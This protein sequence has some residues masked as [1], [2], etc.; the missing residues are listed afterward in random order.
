MSDKAHPED[1][2]PNAIFLHTV[3]SPTA[4]TVGSE[5]QYPDSGEIVYRVRLHGAGGV[6]YRDVTAR[7]GDE[8]A[9]AAL[10][11]FDGSVKVTH[12]EPAPQSRQR[13]KLTAKAA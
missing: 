9:A 10:A 6:P 8:A 5:V 4:A 12:I 2:A 1:D 3:A 11:G 13:E 7:T